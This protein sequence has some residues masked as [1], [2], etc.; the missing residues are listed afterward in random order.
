MV[1]KIAPLVVIVGETASGKSGLAIMLAKQFDGEIIAADSRTIYKGMDIGTA[2]PSKQDQR[3]VK[4]YLIDIIDPDESYSVFRFKHDA[5]SAI[6]NI[7]SRGKLP[8]MVGGSGLYIDSVIFD[9][10]FN[11]NNLSRDSKN[12]RH[13]N[14]SVPKLNNKIRQNTLIIGIK[15]SK[16][17]LEKRIEERA[18]NMLDQGFAREVTHL[19]QKYKSNSEFLSGIGYRTLVQYVQNKITLNQAKTE[20]VKGDRLLAK[21][22][23]TWFKRN[24]SIHWINEQSEAVE[25]VTTF[26]EQI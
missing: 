24:K 12:P 10:N 16:Q 4:H 26:I 6:S 22:Q 21:R 9:Y 14:K 17:E 3:E 8:I 11:V 2:K 19:L 13:L 7:S 5:L 18:Q 15:C 23:R 20:L 1:A 25:L